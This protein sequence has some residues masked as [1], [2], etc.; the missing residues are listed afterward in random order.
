MSSGE[1]GLRSPGHDLGAEALGQVAAAGH[2]V[3]RQHPRAAVDGRDQ[4]GQADRAGAE[5][6]HLLARPQPGTGQRVDG[7]RGGLDEARAVRVQVAGLEDQA[8]RDLEPLG[9]AAVEVHADQAERRADV[10]PPDAAGIAATARQQRPDRD[11]LAPGPFAVPRVVHD[12]GHLVA[13]DS[14]V[15]VA[16]SGERA[17]VAGKQ[18]EVGAADTHPFGSHDN[19][20]R[21]GRGPVRKRPRPPSRRVIWSLR[22]APATPLCGCAEQRECRESWP[23][24]HANAE[25]P[26][27]DPAGQ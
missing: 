7:H 2:R 26:T 23:L 13:L 24:P 22:P 1:L 27:A 15:E 9:Q 21:P 4:R 25:I 20:D 8:G 3:D 12:R 16:G 6:H 10:G 18:V 11:P 14:R 17:H 19:V 5:H